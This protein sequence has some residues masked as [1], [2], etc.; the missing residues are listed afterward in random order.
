[1][2]VI[3]DRAESPFGPSNTHNLQ[4]HQ[5]DQ[6]TIEYA[7]QPEDEAPIDVHGGNLNGILSI[8]SCDHG[9]TSFAPVIYECPTLQK[10]S[11]VVSHISMT[12]IVQ[13]P[14]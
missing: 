14:C 13:E 11:Y 10:A 8:L 5:K 4:E 3:Q 1:M 2:T 6:K 7:H 9:G 12:K